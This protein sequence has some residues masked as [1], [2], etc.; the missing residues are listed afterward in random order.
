MLS[1][2]KLDIIVLLYYLYSL[3]RLIFTENVP[4]INNNFTILTL[5]LSFYFI[6]KY[7]FQK[8]T[9]TLVNSAFI[10]ILSFCTAVFFQAI[11]GLFQAHNLFGFYSGHFITTGSFENPSPYAGY[12][13][14]ALPFAFGLY[15]LFNKKYKLNKIL[16][17]TGLLTFTACVLLLP[18]T[19]ERGDWLAAISGMTVVV[20]YKY[21][22]RKKFMTILNTVYKKILMAIFLVALISAIM[23]GLYNIRPVSA[24]GRILMWKVTTNIIKDYPVFGAGYNRFAQI[25]GNYQADYFSEKKRDPLE[26]YVAGNVR[27]AHNEFIQHFAELGIVG[28]FL[29][30]SIFFIA[31]VRTNELKK[32]NECEYTLESKLVI[33]SK[34]SLTAIGVSS[35]FAFPLQILPTLINFIFLLSMVSAFG[36]KK[37]KQIN[38]PTK[39]LKIIAFPFALLIVIFAVEEYKMFESNKK[40]KEA[41]MLTATG[42]YDEAIQK[43]E[44][45]YQDYKENGDFL[46]NY[47]GALYFNGEYR[48]ALKVF[49]ETK[50][51]NSSNNLYI[52]L[53][54]VYNALSNY[55]KAEASYKK[56]IN[57]IP[58]RL[59][60]RYLL[61]KS[62]IKANN[63][64]KAIEL[65]KIVLSMKAKFLS[66]A[67]QQIKSELIQLLKQ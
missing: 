51:Y 32:N 5:I 53:G 35:L 47:G 36:F 58:N 8:Y 13:A 31:I 57:I 1:L 12:I 20:Y 16:K 52:L 38:I 39:F 45:I 33:A 18:L 7:L 50:K 44:E 30:I 40:W 64:K 21:D 19:K 60:P 46:L 11:I 54:N 41:K 61:V 28:F 66:T 25:Y 37:Y 43:Y 63:Y 48:K 9:V 15:L 22:L 56:A 17:Y 3:V 49:N 2:N 34:S 24:F 14:S 62:Y 67:E 59:Y 10:L 23:V 65:A 55:K 27:R 6:F 29:V 26:V 42:I 4:V